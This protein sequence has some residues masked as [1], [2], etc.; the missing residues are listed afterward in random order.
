MIEAMI[1]LVYA[2]V[3]SLSA[4]KTM[5]ILI[6]ICSNYSRKYAMLV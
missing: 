3:S 5:L 1:F 6:R 4:F 2:I